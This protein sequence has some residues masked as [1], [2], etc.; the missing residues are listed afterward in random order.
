M[1]E[2]QIAYCRSLSPD[3]QAR[4]PFQKP[5]FA[6]IS[7]A[8]LA[9]Q[10]MLQLMA[11]RKI[12]ESWLKKNLFI[13]DRQS[14]EQCTSS[15]VA[16][17]KKS[18]IPPNIEILA[19]A[20]AGLGMDAFHLG[21][22]IPEL[23][24]FE[25]NQQRAEALGMN[26][27]KIREG[28][29]NISVGHMEE[30]KLRQLAGAGNRFLLYAD[31]DRRDGDG[32]RI[33]GWESYRPD[34]REFCKILRGSGAL[35]LL[36]LSPLEDPESLAAVIPETRRII[37]VSV[38][39]EVKEVLMMIE[40]SGEEKHPVYEAVELRNSGE[41]FIIPIPTH[42]EGNPEHNHAVPGA[43]ILDPLASLRKGRFAACMAEEGGWKC[44]SAAGRL[45]TSAFA[46]STFPGRVFQIKNVYDSLAA[47][48]REFTKT[49]CHVV[50]RD[51]PADAEEIRKK[52]NLTETGIAYLFC[53][54][55]REGKN[56]YVHCER[57]NN[58]SAV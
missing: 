5:V 21:E 1:T 19:D 30:E 7:N 36:K 38:H 6:D 25:E 42:L 57:T 39:N 20:C 53:Y 24:L 10:A 28:K 34:I 51:F 4:L 8:R 18:L 23:F 31:P 29:T 43:F 2:E 11:A 41:V 9:S 44:L 35:L 56:T 16:A 17:W 52:L 14:L 27:A 15:L 48:R 54:R 37:L 46:P 13:P 47:F 55:N 50:A 12:P 45:F 58:F 3:S 32:G 33:R 22:G 40:F 49:N 26:A